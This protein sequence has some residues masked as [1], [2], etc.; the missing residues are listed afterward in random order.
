MFS[1]KIPENMCSVPAFRG[2]PPE[3]LSR[4]VRRKYAT[5]SIY[6]QYL[7]KSAFTLF[8]LSA[9]PPFPLPED[10]T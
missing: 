2:R 10:A 7:Y 9:L 3:A 8:T 6:C 4:L 5:Q 1:E